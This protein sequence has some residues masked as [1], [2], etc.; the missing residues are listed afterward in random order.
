MVS[1]PEIF[2]LLLK[3]MYDVDPTVLRA[4]Y[5]GTFHIS[6]SYAILACGNSAHKAKI[7]S[8]QRKFIRIMTNIG[9][10]DNCHEQSSKILTTKCV[11]VLECLKYVRAKMFISLDLCVTNMKREIANGAFVHIH[12]LQNLNL[13][14]KY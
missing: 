8:L 10:R 4:A 11:Y 9:Y 5:S 13:H 6:L 12:L 14:K 7:F 3:L 1:F 2:F